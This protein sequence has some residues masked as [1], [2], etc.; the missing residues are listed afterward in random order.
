MLSLD[1]KFP[2][3]NILAYESHGDV[4]Y[5][6]PD[7][8]DTEGTWFYWAFRVRG[9]AGRTLTFR[10]VSGHPVGVRGPAVSTDGRLTW[11]WVEDAFDKDAFTV[12][13]PSGCEE[14]YFAFAPLYTQE[15]W[16]RFLAA[17]PTG[18]FQA[19]SFATSRKGR[20]VEILHLGAEPDKAPCH[21]LLTARHHCCEMIADYTLEGFAAT[22]AADA[23]REASWLRENVSALIVPFADK[24]GVE[25]GD[26]GKNR[27]PHDHARDYGRDDPIYPETIAISKLVRTLIK[28]HG[29]LDFV[30]DLHCP[31]IRGDCNETVYMVGKDLPGDALFRRRFGSLLERLN[32]PDALPYGT[33]NDIP[34]GVGWNTAANYTKGATLPGWAGKLL[35]VR[36]VAS[37]EIPYAN[38]S[39]V[40]VTPDAARQLGVG[41]A[42]ALARFLGKGRRLR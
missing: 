41:I 36:A 35:G 38:A 16:T 33:K 21:A 24:D 32:P 5:V 34:Y 30:A 4:L 11:R 1:C 22:L 19:G 25:D 17:L 29:K 15:N 12:S 13:I 28:R 27:L 37:F 3:G 39:G 6:K 31:W 23:S 14:A 9:A 18:S 40:P 26:Q 8:R 7:P 20:P 42:R 2:G 10:F